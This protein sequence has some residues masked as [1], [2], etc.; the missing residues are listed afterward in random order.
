MHQGRVRLDSRKNLFRKSGQTLEQ[1]AQGG[2]EIA[3]PGG[4]LEKGICGTAGHG[5]VGMAG[6]G[7]HWAR[8]S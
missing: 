7:S 4:L 2:G 8:L 1:A 3:V 5:L 6:M